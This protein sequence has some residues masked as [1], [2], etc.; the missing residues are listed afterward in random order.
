MSEDKAGIDYKAVL[1][2]LEARKAAL[3]TAIQ[4]IR[5][6]VGQGDGAAAPAPRQA[7]PGP[8]MEIPSDAFFGLNLPEACRKYLS[9]AKRP[10]TTQ[11]ILEAVVAGGFKTLSK[12]LYSNTYTALSRDPEVVKIDRSR[13]GLVAWYPGVKIKGPAPAGE[14][15][16]PRPDANGK[17]KEE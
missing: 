14:K 2:D 17:G 16:A 3:E 1:A 6:F 10:R 8:I 11:E 4:A 12:N 9:M 13:W 15:A 7:A 5:G